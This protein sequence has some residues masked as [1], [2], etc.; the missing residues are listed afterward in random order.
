MILGHEKFGH[1][2]HKVVVLHDWFCDHTSY[3]PALP[4]LDLTTFQYAFIDLRGY[5][6][7]QSTRGAYTVEE[8]T[9]DIL[10]TVQHIG[11]NNFHLIGYSMSAL[12]AQ[13]ICAEARDK[14]TSFIAVTPVNARGMPEADD[15]TF[16]FMQAAAFDDDTK[17][18]AAAHMMTSHQHMDQFAA[19]KV[20]RWRETATPEARVGYCHMFV[21]TNILAKVQGLETPMGVICTT[22][23]NEAHR[24]NVIQST[25]VQWFPHVEI[26]EIQNAGHYP[27]QETPVAFADCVNTFLL[28]HIR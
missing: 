13:L 28:K 22:H 14:I 20:K 15:A 10:E 27:M 12:I 8:A 16:A 11:W 18:M 3:L 5:G 26:M 2:S 17:A 25:F 21:K 24:K 4:Y 23:D 19:Y 9:Q 1:G 7:S 6:L